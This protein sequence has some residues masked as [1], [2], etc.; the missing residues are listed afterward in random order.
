MKVSNFLNG[1][2]FYV[3]YLSV[4]VSLYYFVLRLKTTTPRNYNTTTLLNHNTI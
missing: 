4:I 3:L 1:Y 2:D